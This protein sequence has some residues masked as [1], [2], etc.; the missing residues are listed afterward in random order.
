MLI[1]PCTD[2]FEIQKKWNIFLGIIVAAVL[3][4]LF[5]N[6][7]VYADKWTLNDECKSDSWVGILEDSEGYPIYNVKIGT[8]KNLSSGS[9][10]ELFFTDVNGFFSIPSS[11]YTGFVKI[12]K[13]GF[14]TKR[15]NLDCDFVSSESNIVKKG[16]T[17][18]ISKP[19]TP[20]SDVILEFE[21]KGIEL[22]K[23]QE[24]DN[25]RKYFD[26]ILE[27]EPDNVNALINK[28]TAEY[29]MGLTFAS[30]RHFMQVLEIEPDNREAI[31]WRDKISKE[32]QDISTE[33]NIVKNSSGKILEFSV[34]G[35]IFGVGLFVNGFRSM[36]RKKM[37]ESIPTSKIRSLAV[38][39]AEIFGKAVTNSKLIRAPFSNDECIACRVVIQ[40]Y[41]NYSKYKRWQTI[42]DTILC[43]E[44]MVEDE[45]GRVQV[46]PQGATF[47]IPKSFEN[48]S[49]WLND[50]PIHTKDFLKKQNLNYEGFLGVNKSMRY[51]E[52]AIKSG[53]QV[54]VL[55]RAD[56]NP[57][58]EDGSS[59]QGVIDMMMQKSKNPNIYYI[60][61]RSEKHLLG[62]LTSTIL[63][64]IVGGSF[65][66]GGSLL[67]ILLW[68]TNFI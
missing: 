51:I 13:G 23:N 33:P 27:I 7:I 18:S 55:G 47:D 3:L 43:N 29:E 60:S 67:V 59:Q 39:I 34:V 8:M 35:I 63:G 15:L 50:P 58:V 46:D 4:F 20:T 37:I 31:Q 32:N 30:Y 45:T 24:Y 52:Y 68:L 38:G 64:Q 36:H 17:I 49:G 48:K 65:L 19:T 41:N 44:F 16:S 1:K 12:S 11:S 22:L 53:D 25:S 57:H 5:P 26:R 42:R 28:A 40:E 14:E 21:N 2:Y 61:N 10:E 62:K 9:V 56:D 54:Y 66:I 6:Q